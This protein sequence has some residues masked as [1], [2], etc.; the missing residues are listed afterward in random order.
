MK[1][2]IKKNW[3]WLLIV[4][5]ILTVV[6]IY[7]KYRKKKPE[8]IITQKTPITRN[9]GPSVDLGV[10][11]I[12]PVVSPPVSS[13]TPTVLAPPPFTGVPG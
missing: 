10:H 6:L 13:T 12:E 9:P 1:E 8:D 2:W 7:L 4:A 3:K 11:K 5:I